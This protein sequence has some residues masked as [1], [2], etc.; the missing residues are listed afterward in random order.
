M[1]FSRFWQDPVISGVLSTGIST[2]IWPFFLGDDQESGAFQ[3][4]GKSLVEQDIQ[5]W[6]FV[7]A[8]SVAIGL[9]VYSTQKWRESRDRES[10]S[11]KAWFSLVNQKLKDCT[12]ARIYLRKFDHP[13]NFR[14]EHKAVLMEMM[15]T[16]KARIA[17]GADI[18]IIS[19]NDNGEK[20]GFEWLVSELSEETCV[21]GFVK[22]VPTQITTN[23]SSTYIFDDKNI[24]FNKRVGGTV[25]YYCESHSGSILFEFVKSG[26]EGYWGRV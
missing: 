13:D 16:I 3:G 22:I 6:I 2:V 24:V 4:W 5:N 11:S 9:A 19:Y 25:Q 26:F 15:E 23:S 12:S 1:A 8:V 18:K 7:L 10:L 20:T 14:Q 21:E 17:A